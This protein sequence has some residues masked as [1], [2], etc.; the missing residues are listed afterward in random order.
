MR[1]SS[2]LGPTIEALLRPAKLPSGELLNGRVMCAEGEFCYQFTLQMLRK[3]E[4]SGS[5]DG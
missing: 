1:I 5:V 4:S 2:R 3:M